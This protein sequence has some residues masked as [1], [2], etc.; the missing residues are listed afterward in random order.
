[1]LSQWI[2]IIRGVSGVLSD[3]S[4]EMQ[5]SAAT[6]VNLDSTADYLYIGQSFPFNNFF[7]QVGTANTS[8]SVLTVE[9]WDGNSWTA[10][11]DVIDGTKASGKTFAQS[12]VV[13][14]SP[15]RNTNW[16]IVQDT[17]D[18]ETTFGLQ[19]LEIY[20]M[21]WLRISVSADLYASTSIN[22]IGY[23]FC[24]DE[25]LLSVAPEINKFL[26][27]WA[28]GKT[29]WIEQI[30]LGSQHMVAK[31]KEIGL[32][33]TNGQILRFDDVSIP[34][35]YKTLELIYWGLGE[36]YRPKMLE[37]RDWSD[38]LLTIERFTIDRNKDGLL[39]RSELSGSTGGLIR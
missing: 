18:E 39:S 7:V 19:S 2:R 17:S 12:G 14:F 31:L 4:I 37:A 34:T 3:L 26:T 16:Q 20:D 15:S 11:V 13:M 36:A 23:S 1:M 9:Y 32:V 28:A 29:N 25:Q 22:K 10:A 24:T 27:G 33:V 35:V 38:K 30:I 6:T 8:D 21:Y 5:T